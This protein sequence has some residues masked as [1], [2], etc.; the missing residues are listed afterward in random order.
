LSLS[1]SQETRYDV[2]GTI[3]PF[4][5]WYL[6]QKQGSSVAER[7]LKDGAWI[8][9]GISRDPSKT[10]AQVLLEKGVEVVAG[11]LDNTAS[12][13]TAIAGADVVFGISISFHLIRAKY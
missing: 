11:D 2:L 6:C 10:S 9:R 5:D 7:F 1:A 12:I 13:A 8:V 3:A 4:E